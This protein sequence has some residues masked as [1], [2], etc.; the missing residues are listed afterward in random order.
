VRN[1][2]AQATVSTYLDRVIRA[3]TQ[4]ARAW[5][6]IAE[7]YQNFNL[8]PLARQVTERAYSA[9]YLEAQTLSQ[10]L[11]EIT[12]ALAA[13]DKPLVRLTLENTQR[14]Y[15]IALLN[16]R[17][18]YSS[19]TSELN[20]FGF[21]PDFIPFP[22]LA[23]PVNISVPTNAF[24]ELL[25]DVRRKVDFAA[26]REVAALSEGRQFD[27]DTEEFQAELANIRNSFDN[28]LAALCGTFTVEDL[29][30][31]QQIYPA[32]PA[33]APLNEF[34][35]QFGDPC[36]LV[37]GSEIRRARGEVD[38]RALA[39]ERVLQAQDNTVARIEQ[40]LAAMDRECELIVGTADMVWEAEGTANSLRAGIR[41]TNLIAE[42]ARGGLDL[43]FQLAELS[44]CEPPSLTG[45]GNCPVEI[46]KAAAY[47]VAAGLVFAT[48][49]AGRVVNLALETQIDAIDQETAYFT[50]V[51]DCE[52]AQVKYR[53]TIFDLAME[54]RLLDIDVQNAMYELEIAVDR[55]TELRNEASRL[56]QQR[57][58]S[59]EMAVN[60]AAAKNDPN[61]RIYRNDAFFNADLAFF[62]ALQALYRLTRVYEYFTSQSYAR[63]DELYLTR[64][65]QRG[66]F[67][68]ENYLVRLENDFSSFQESFGNPDIRVSTI[69]LRDDILRIEPL[70]GSTGRNRRKMLAEMRESLRDPSNLDTNGYIVLP[71]T[72][73]LDQ[74]SPLTRNHKVLYIEAELQGDARRL[75]DDLARV[76]VRQRG[77]GVVQSVNDV[78]DFYAFPERTA[79]IDAFV[80]SNKAFDSRI[81][82]SYRL[83]DRPLVNTQWELV[84][85][86]V[87][88]A[89]NRDIDLDGL[90]DIVLYVYYT[91]FTAL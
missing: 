72:T 89:E 16:M 15:N 64:M 90:S 25:P 4:K 66:D 84:L 60:V 57:T 31:E 44:S 86:L 51:G 50:A 8:A 45:V 87:D 9:A 52:V 41:T 70:D 91:D 32:I 79:V 24:E 13:S 22:A 82:R 56:M 67:N 63:L 47:G 53:T 6:E 46:P 49:T 14:T 59:I 54:Q 38:L 75:G 68:L 42:T 27:V 55:A 21:A 23:D 85:N 83:R 29:S 73:L 12:D 40:N 10:L 36:G 58:E 48:E 69:S 17:E 76:Y 35:S 65:V 11:L 43:A 39:L 1:F 3:S 2:V 77:T 20:Y 62:D 74:L 26:Q 7:R 30:G 78:K 61:V 18:V 71:F 81:Y 88:E 28:Q 5:S 19:L 33:F 34:F 80:N 37:E